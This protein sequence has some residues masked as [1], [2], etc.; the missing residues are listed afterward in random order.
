MVDGPVGV[1]LFV[2]EIGAALVAKAVC[3][4]RT[5]V[6]RCAVMAGGDPADFVGP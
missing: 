6:R 3:S 4:C 1:A 2:E 5:A